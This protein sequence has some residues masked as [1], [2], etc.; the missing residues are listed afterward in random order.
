MHIA[1]R[2]SSFEVYDILN[3]KDSDLQDMRDKVS[4]NVAKAVALLSNNGM[5]FNT[6]CSL[7][8]L[9]SRIHPLYEFN[10]TSLWYDC[11]FLE[12]SKSG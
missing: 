9:R 4:H 2:K 1:R 7:K 5:Q 3:L 10:C 12:Q 8:P 11:K 6:I